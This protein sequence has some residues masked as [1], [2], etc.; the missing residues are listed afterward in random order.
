ML[1]EKLPAELWFEIFK[2]FNTDEL[3]DSYYGLNNHF[4]SLLFNY[5]RKCI[6]NLQ[7]SSKT[8]LNIFY[9]HY[10]P[11]LYNQIKLLRLYNND[12]S[13]QQINLL[14]S[15]NF[16]LDRFISLRS[17][18][19]SHIESIEILYDMTTRLRHLEEFTRLTINN[20]TLPE[21]DQSI[22][23]LINSIWSLPNL[24]YSQFDIANENEHHFPVPQIYSPPL[25]H[26]ELINFYCR[27]RDL[28]H[29]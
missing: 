16:T 28:V 8:N 18:S 20:F 11:M 9:E 15:Q 24:S 10:L 6:V 23:L 22:L 26:V 29:L 7:S 14:L 3:L 4:H 21:R 19:L 17:L 13:P 5:F 25:K 1:L 12:D 27:Q 2:F